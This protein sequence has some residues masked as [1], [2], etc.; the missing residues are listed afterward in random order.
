MD[1]EEK[2]PI[3]RNKDELQGQGQGAQGEDKKI[4]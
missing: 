1:H 3:L 4:S 2:Y